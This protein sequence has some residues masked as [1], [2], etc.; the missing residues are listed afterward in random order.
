VVAVNK[1]KPAAQATHAAFEV[2]EAP[3][4]EY[5][6]VVHPM[7]AVA[8]RVE[9][10]TVCATLTVYPPA[11]PAPPASAVMV[12]PAATPL[13]TMAWPTARVPVGEPVTVS[14]V[15][16]MVPLNAPAPVPAGQ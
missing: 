2:A 11:P 9:V 6:P 5:V 14:A 1:Q 15:P 12:V 10:D 3:P 8:I 4:S 13:P 7:P 16:A